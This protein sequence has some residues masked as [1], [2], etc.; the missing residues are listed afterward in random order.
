[1]K[2]IEFSV[3]NSLVV[4]L[5]AVFVTVAGLLTALSMNREAFP[6]FSFDIVSINTTYPG[7][8][9]EEVEK[10]ITQPIEEEL[11][12]ISDL[13]KVESISAEGYSLIYVT[14]DPDA[15]NKSRI[16]TDIQQAVDRVE[17][18]PIDLEDDPIATEIRT[19]DSPII[20][21]VLFGDMSRVEL[22]AQ[23]EEIEKQ[24]LDISLVADIQK[25]G[26][27]EQEIWVELNPKKLKRYQLSINEVSSAIKAR[28]INVPGGIF[29]DGREELLVRTN[30]EFTQPEEI[31]EIVIRANTSGKVIQVKDVG[32]ARYAFEDSDTTVRVNGENSVSLVVVKKAVGDTI[33][34]VEQVQSVTDNFI[35]NSNSN[36]QYSFINDV[37][38]YVKRRLNILL[39]NGWIGLLLVII[40]LFV[41]LSPRVALWTALGL[42]MAMGMG[43]W[44]MGMFDITINLISM[45]GLILILGM[46]VDD[47]IVVAESIYRFL[48][49]GKN[50]VEAAILGTKE[51]VKPV[52][53]TILTTVVFFLPLAF[54]SGIF[55][56]FLKPIPIVVIITLLASLVE[57][58]II[59]PSHLADFG[60]SKKQ[61]ESTQNN[62]PQVKHYSKWFESLKNLYG[63]CMQVIFKGHFVVTSL[64]LTILI[65]GIH[66]GFKTTSINLFPGKDI[67]IF[68][69][70][71]EGEVGTSLELTE[72]K[73]EALEDLVKKLPQDELKDYATQIGLVQQ[74]PNDPATLRGSHVAQV[75]V[76]LTAKE[77]R[78][79]ETKQITDQL[80]NE[81]KNVEG[82]KRVWIDEVKPGPPQ[83]KA[84]SLRIRGPN[85]ETSREIV[86]KIKTDLKKIPGVRDIRDD[87]EPGKKE[88]Q[89][90]LD[91][92]NIARASLSPITV[93]QTVRAAVD[94][95]LTTVIKE[96]EDEVNVF[97][98]L[99]ENLNQSYTT[100]N[101]LYVQNPFGFQVPLS[102]LVSF[103]EGQSV[104]QI[105]HYDFKRV[106]GL[107]ANIDE[108]VTSS[109]EVNDIIRNKYSDLGQQYFGYDLFFGGEEK[110]TQESLDSLMRA[111]ILALM[112]AFFILAA[113][114]NSLSQPLLIL[115]AIPYGL[116]AAIYALKFHGEP[117]SFLAFLGLI[118]LSGVTVNDSVIL[119]DYINQK[120]KTCEDRLEAVLIACKTR[121]RPVILT[122]VTTVLGLAPVAYGIGGND[123][124]LKPMALTMT[125][126]L[127]FGTILTLVLI[128]CAY[129]TLDS[130]SSVFK[131]R[132]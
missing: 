45:F 15:K 118:G 131:K 75:A 96:G 1:M 56:K 4:N 6:L 64:S 3:K 110:D 13:D 30:A 88:V 25:K 122:S 20:E 91:E 9:P 121:L 39:S 31:D 82:F 76:Y 21:L 92:K 5:L 119:I 90:I 18:L 61:K 57:C 116:F 23:A 63:Q 85:F 93:A 84:V 105:K 98:K 101:D 87:F 29:D 54:M 42:P 120:R 16:V 36:L 113:A 132:S 58:F 35:K 104:S 100:L 38:V 126:G 107:S 127:A 49:Q 2:W 52:V 71:A 68:F 59:L 46:L 8:T 79:R 73:I 81:I 109:K 51:V 43:L 125:W 89:V 66:Y 60:A 69:I 40:S 77:E 48:E 22:Q 123:P 80:R 33:N 95:D 78:Q 44:M 102:R 37:S 106:V 72:K 28:N 117:L 19:Q 10:L 128:P 14:I 129:L 47:S 130:I 34:L 7:A 97:V 53:M 86:N 24:L 114:F 83:G 62:T 70:R 74:D 103:Q 111:A 108:D 32:Q 94:G 115:L 17:G 55:G 26:W 27:K 11:R 12:S 41:F 124:F 50:P 65:A 99:D 112:M 67:E